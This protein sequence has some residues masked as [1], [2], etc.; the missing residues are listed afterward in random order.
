MKQ[1]PEVILRQLAQRVVELSAITFGVRGV[2]KAVTVRIL[3]D[4]LIEII[5]KVRRSKVKMNIHWSRLEGVFDTCESICVGLV[6]RKKVIEA[7]GT[8][9]RCSTTIRIHC[10]PGAC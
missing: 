7:K 3:P 2:G 6:G 1:L 4:N 10:L 9:E 8:Y 5:P